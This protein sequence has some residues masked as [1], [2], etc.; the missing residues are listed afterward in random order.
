MLLFV[1]LCALPP[2]FSAEPA[3]LDP[4]QSLQRLMEGNRRY[5]AG[6]VSAGKPLA[7]RRAEVAKAQHPF[8]VIVGC[9][10]SRVPPEIIL[11]QGLGDLFV[12][13]LAGNVVDDCARES[14]EY[15]LDHLGVPLVVVLG[16]KRC[17][18]VGAAL[19]A[20][21]DEDHLRAIMKAIAP[22][23]ERARGKEGDVWENAVKE[24]AVL[25]AA[26]LQASA[27]IIAPLVKSGKVRVL[28]AYYDL[29]TGEVVFL[30]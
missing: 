16:H 27:P 28:A 29:D 17:G 4:E 8:A 1:C 18:A 26:Q 15:A 14:I 5:V 24:N 12:V 21:P 2:A 6:Q 11:D 22:A 23:V 3:K 13:R 9:S 7:G 19:E 30:K 25:T 10:D 20:R